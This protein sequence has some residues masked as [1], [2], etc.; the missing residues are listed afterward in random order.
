MCYRED[1]NKAPDME[2]I[3]PVGYSEF[4]AQVAQ[5][6]SFGISE[7]EAKSWIDESCISSSDE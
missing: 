3:E 7:E 5:M 4:I 2:L 6:I 1:M